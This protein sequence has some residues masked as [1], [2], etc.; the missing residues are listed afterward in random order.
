M[1]MTLTDAFKRAFAAE[2]AGEVARARAIYDDVLR[3]VP[4]HPGA[5][6]GIARQARAERAHDRA[7]ELL[8][9]ALKSAEQNGLP[10]E[11]LW[12]E[13]SFVA[14]ERGDRQQAQNACDAALRANPAFVPALLRAGDLALADARYSNA[15]EHFRSALR[16]GEQ[17]LGAWVG[18]ARA[19]AG[20]RRFTEAQ[21]ALAR[22]TRLAPREPAVFAAAAWIA[23]QKKEWAEAERVCTTGLD[24]APQDAALLSLLG[25]AQRMAG[26]RDAA[27]QSLQLALLQRG[28]D[29]ALRGT[30]GAVLLDLGRAEQ[31]REELEAAVALGDRSAETLANLGLA[32]LAVS[33]YERAEA[34]FARAFDA[35]PALTPALVDL[36]SARQYLCA[37]D[38]L[39]ALQTRLA[40]AADDPNSDPRVSPF[41]AMAIGFSPARQLAVGRRWSRAMLP[42]ASAP[43]IIAKRGDRLRIGYLSSDFRDHPTGRLMAG[44]IEA[45]DR[46]RVEVFGYGYG[47]SRDSP[48]RQ[49]IASAF[50][51][52]RD[53][54]T[55]GDAEMAATIRADRIDVLIDRKGH[56]RGGRLA[57]LSSRPAAVQLHYMSFPATLGYDA[58]DGI[59]ADDV[60]VPRGE[61][62]F[63]H[64]RVLRLPRC[65]FVTDGTMPLP[66]R[67]HRNEH[68]L[69]DDALVLASLNQTYKL[70]RDVFAIWMDAL[71]H[72]AKAV[73]WLHADHP[74]VQSNLRE[75]AARRG[76]APERLIFARS[77]PHD[78]H[79]GRVRCADLALDTLPCGSHTTGVDALFAGVPM[80][81]CRGTTFAGRVGASLL[82]AVD[83]PE[84][85]TENLENYRATLLDLVQ[86]RDRIRAYANH[87][88]AGRYRLEL[89][90][91]KAFA[92]DF[93]DLLINAYDILAPKA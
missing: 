53:L 15:D 89:F 78:A 80:L 16:Q 60:V 61:E 30:L 56:T 22:A 28:N 7:A 58:I 90:D 51:Q 38:G 92:V 5:L 44:L 88:D 48:L 82:R 23:L 6:L 42:P 79:I 41:V 83:L 57:A 76:V 93:E 31:A 13:S 4:E 33:E 25:E 54:G 17:H 40:A 73:L 85:I 10:T 91:T 11:A 20:L 36:I 67:A 37:W 14:F 69:P 49:R 19:L 24:I 59:I 75:E 68:A 64:E 86:D 18:V 74:C 8:E 26:K 45:H 29:V 34:L 52:W 66:E 47:D 43:G 72:A 71:R 50:D 32:W 27:R 2:R 77:L 12:V 81:T 35:N 87:L 70:T 39:D 55:T 1:L 63:Y 21:S 65:Y 9:R 3:A 84:L 62:K 46:R